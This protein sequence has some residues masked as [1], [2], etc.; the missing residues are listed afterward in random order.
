MEEEKIFSDPQSKNYEL[1]QTINQVL[2]ELY[3]GGTKMVKI[4]TT[5]S[6]VVKWVEKSYHKM[7]LELCKFK[8]RLVKESEKK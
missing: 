4:N 3:L 5:G 8:N 1:I 7:Y 2:F 6:P